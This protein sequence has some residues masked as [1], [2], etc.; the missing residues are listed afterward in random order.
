MI[1]FTLFVLILMLREVVMVV[2]EIIHKMLIDESFNNYS[3]PE[4]VLIAVSEVFPILI[5]YYGIYLSSFK[6]KTS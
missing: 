5:I 3:P 6:A 4:K 2:Y 1:Y